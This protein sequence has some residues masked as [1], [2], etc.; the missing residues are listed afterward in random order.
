[1]VSIRS[2]IQGGFAGTFAA[3]AIM[4]MN[5]A[6]GKVP[7]LH[8]AKTLNTVLG[9]TNHAII[10]WIAFFMIGTFVLGP[11]FAVL[12]PRIRI[13][14]NLLKGLMFGVLV[15]L[16]MMMVLVPLAG[17]GVFAMHRSPIVPGVTLAVALVYGLVLSA[18]YAWDISA[19]QPQTPNRP[20][21]TSHHAA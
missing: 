15:W 19:L 21:G 8:I 10:G 12:T 5:N 11:L 18:V 1:M 16:G 13:K 7:E 3:S 6:I 20:H 4:I 14:V 2:G 9:T 17:G